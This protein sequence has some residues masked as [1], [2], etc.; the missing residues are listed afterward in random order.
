M[1]EHGL[2]PAAV[3]SGGRAV[4]AAG[5]GEVGCPG[6]LGQGLERGERAGEARVGDDLEDGLADRFDINGGPLYAEMVPRGIWHQ[7]SLFRVILPL[8]ATRPPSRMGGSSSRYESP[9]WIR[10]TTS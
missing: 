3:A 6:D 10:P 5:G 7:E 9:G 8:A 1:P 2:A 4:L